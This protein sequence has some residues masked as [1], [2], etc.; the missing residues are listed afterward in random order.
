MPPKKLKAEALIRSVARLGAATL[1]IRHYPQQGSRNEF[2][3][4]LA[5]ALLKNGWSQERVATFIEIIARTAEDEEWGSRVQ[6]VD[7]TAEKVAKGDAVTG[8]TR[9]R[10]L[11]GDD[12]VRRLEQWLQLSGVDPQPETA[13]GLTDLGNARR[14][15][16]QHGTE[17]RFC[18]N[19]NKWLAWDG[20]RW[21]TDDSGEIERRAKSTVRQIYA[22][23]S[24]TVDDESRKAIVGWAKSSESRGRITAMIELAK[25]EPGIPVS[26]Q[27]LD[28]NPWLL[29]CG[30]GTIDLR[31]GELLPYGGENFCTKIIPVGYDPDA[32]CPLFKNF[33]RQILKEN[34]ELISFLQRAVGYALTG[35]TIE[36][37]LFILW[38]CGANGKSTFLEIIREV[39]GRLRSHRGFRSADASEERWRPQ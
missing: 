16:Q 11:V 39:S 14:L 4:A 31:T 8:V 30:N 25:S 19:W 34:R 20:A 21:R 18:Y 10:E 1:L 37:V 32:T 35:S 17:V 2:M 6:S 5:G 7:A 22:E 33:L 3:L 28:A 29:N 9:L 38:G 13:P 15:V 24:R 12:V 26:P 27:E 23:A 36:Q